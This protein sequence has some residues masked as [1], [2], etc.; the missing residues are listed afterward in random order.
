MRR[1]AAA[2]L[3]IVLAACAPADPDPGTHRG[4]VFFQEWSANLDEEGQGAVDAA[5][6]V[7]KRHPGVPVTVIGF[8]DPEGSPQAN[9]DISRLR[10][11]VVVDALIKDGVPAAQ[12]IRQAKGATAFV[13]TSLESRR[14]EIVVNGK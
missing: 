2:C 12:I 4:L 6:A 14:V 11:Q 10:A 9:I 13:S 3:L 8:A 7:V 1:L 5:A